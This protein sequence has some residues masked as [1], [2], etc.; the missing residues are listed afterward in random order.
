MDQ[1]QSKSQ[2]SEGNRNHKAIREVTT[3]KFN[4]QQN[5]SLDI[6]GTRSDSRA[7]EGLA[8]S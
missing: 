2:N 4:I 1:E 7:L 3:L 6:S 8:D 5:I